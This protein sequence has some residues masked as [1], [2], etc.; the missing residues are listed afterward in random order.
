MDDFD[1][2]EI[3]AVKNVRLCAGAVFNLL[4]AVRN[5]NAIET[6]V[7]M[8]ERFAKILYPDYVGRYK[9]TD[10]SH[11]RSCDEKNKSPLPFSEPART[12]A[13]HNDIEE[14]YDALLN[15]ADKFIRSS[16]N[17]IDKNDM[18]WLGRALVGL[19]VEDK[20]IPDDAV[21]F[22]DKDGKDKA[23]LRGIEQTLLPGLI[24][25]ILD[26]VAQNVP[27]NSVGHETVPKWL[28]KIRNANEVERE[29]VS[30]YRKHNLKVDLDIPASIRRAEEGAFYSEQEKYFE[31]ALDEYGNAKTF[32]YNEQSRPLDDFLLNWYRSWNIGKMSQISRRSSS[33]GWIRTCTRHTR[34]SPRYRCFLT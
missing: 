9:Q 22:I 1:P 28:V 14:N 11:F 6:Q 27:D 4:Y 31:K 19:V 26:Y 10:I 24:I 2:Y 17:L 29:R 34:I 32:F 23:Y 13:F 18:A 5:R 3:G 7:A 12:S 25:G 33:G 21:L 15:R 20:E 30:I 16:L 8:Y